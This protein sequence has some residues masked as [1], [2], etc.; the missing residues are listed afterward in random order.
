[1]YA[2]QINN[3]WQNYT[4]SQ[5]RKDNPQI[6]FPADP[7]DALLAEYGVYSVQID[8]QPIYE[9]RYQ[10]LIQGDLVEKNGVVTR[11]WTVEDIPATADMIKT[12][13]QR[14]IL[15]ILP[16]WKQRNLIARAAELAIK[17]SQN[18][19]PDEIEEVSVGQALWDQIKY[20]RVKSNEIETMN[21]IPVDYIHDKYWI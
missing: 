4:I 21:P 12:E 17:G 16:E 14:R 11:G 15:H 10:R 13:A 1:M 6:S 7:S 19:T 8:P 3:G 18:W 2:K 5:L 20:I 9:V